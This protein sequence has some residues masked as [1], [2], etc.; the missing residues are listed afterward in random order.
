MSSHSDVALRN[1]DVVNLKLKLVGVWDSVF[2]RFQG[3]LEA[4][5]L[6]F[7]GDWQGCPALGGPVHWFERFS[8]EDE[9]HRQ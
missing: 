4:R 1:I 2:R 8:R 9:T 6:L 3:S 7:E 5:Q